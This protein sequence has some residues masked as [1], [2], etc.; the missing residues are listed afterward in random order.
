S[1][2]RSGAAGKARREAPRPRRAPVACR[3]TGGAARGGEGGAGGDTP[4]PFFAGAAPQ[5]KRKG[6]LRISLDV[7]RNARARVPSKRGWFRKKRTPADTGSPSTSADQML[8]ER[9][10]VDSLLAPLSLP[11]MAAPS[12]QP[13][14][15][16][17]SVSGVRV[18]WSQRFSGS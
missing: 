18:P 17:S 2:A 11:L 10:V 9:D 4:P 3:P 7:G 8:S 16:S 14:Y 12:P 1:A 13:C 6:V 5:R 15:P